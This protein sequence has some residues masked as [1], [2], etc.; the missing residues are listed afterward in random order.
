[1]GAA[2]LQQGQLG[3]PGFKRRHVALFYTLLCRLLFNPPE[4]SREPRSFK[5]ERKFFVGQLKLN[6]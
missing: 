5:F 3:L 1:M 2:G 6:L 4:V